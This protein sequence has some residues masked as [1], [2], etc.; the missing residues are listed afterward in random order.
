MSKKNNLVNLFE[1]FCNE[2]KYEI[3]KNQI[4]IIKSL[5]DFLHPKKNLFS[6]FYKKKQNYCFYLS[7][8]VGVGKT[9]ILD[10]VFN[11]LS[12]NKKRSHFNEFMLNFHDFRNT[13]KKE[14]SI[15]NFVKNLKSK[16]DLIYLDE[17]QVTN[18]V[19]A[20]ILGKL[21]ELILSENI[22]VLISSNTK[23]D[24]LYKDGLQRE[25]F[26]TFIKLIDSKSLKKEL[27]LDVDYR[28]QFKDKNQRIFYPINANT[29]F[30]INQYFRIIT[31]SKKKDKKIIITKGREFEISDFYEGIARFNFKELCDENLGSE[32]YLNLANECKHIL[33]EEIPLFD[34]YNSNQQLRFITLID[35]LYDKKIILTISAASS[36]ENIG[37][38][39]KHLEIFKRTT[40]RLYEM[41]QS[42]NYLI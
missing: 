13:Q 22:K 7:G 24:D 30:N 34:D 19:D 11:S 32:D 16:Y 33:I 6:L 23:L 40:S 42:K 10:L 36:I 37:S 31:R 4:E 38:S 12:I 15:S 20:M 1:N 2:K 8:N 29:L 17:F 25:Q 41:I 26:E 28:Q 39:K 9:M 18:I 3:N 14:N 27:T 35:I 5:D 21:F